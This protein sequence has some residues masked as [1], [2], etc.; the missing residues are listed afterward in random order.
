MFTPFAL[1]VV[2]VLGM[3]PPWQ[4]LAVAYLVLALAMA[5]AIRAFGAPPDH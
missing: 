5:I 2:L 3:R 4:I 1:A